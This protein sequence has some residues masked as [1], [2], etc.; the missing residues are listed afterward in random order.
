MSD[1]ADEKVAEAKF[2]SPV[3]GSVFLRWVGSHHSGSTDTLVHTRLYH[4][5][6]KVKSSEH[7]WKIY[8][9]D[10]LDSEAG[11]STL[12]L[13]IILTLDSGVQL[14]YKVL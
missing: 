3:A 13:P 2:L 8:T 10:I 12:L 4:V 5:D 1:D 11:R 14:N 6:Q 7:N 9:T